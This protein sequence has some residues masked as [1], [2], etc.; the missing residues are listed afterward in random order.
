MKFSQVFSRTT[1]DH[2]IQDFSMRKD[3]IVSIRKKRP[4]KVMNGS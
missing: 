3:S 1:R 4:I 2:M